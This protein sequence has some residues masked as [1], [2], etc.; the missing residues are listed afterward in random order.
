MRGLIWERWRLSLGE[1][2]EGLFG[3]VC[4]QGAT[5]KGKDRQGDGTRGRV[6]LGGRGECCW[7]SGHGVGAEEVGPRGLEVPVWP[8]HQ[9]RQEGGCLRSP[10]CGS[11]WDRI[12]VHPRGRGAFWGGDN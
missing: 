12:P 2:E 11:L 8:P 6:E 7:G 5:G 9:S 3:G 1:L 4:V 10:R